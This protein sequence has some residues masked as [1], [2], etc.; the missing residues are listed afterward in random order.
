MNKSINILIS[1]AGRRVSLVEA[2]K[3]ELKLIFPEGK[4]FATDMN[5]SLSAACQV[6]DLAFKVGRI[7][8]KNTILEILDIC[9]KQNIKLV[10]PT[11]DT[12][13]QI[14]AEHQALFN[15][16]GIKII[17]SDLGFIKICRNKWLTNDFFVEKNIPI[18]AKIDKENLSYPFFIKPF[19][20]S[21]SKDIALIQEEK[22]LTR[23]QM[24]NPKLMFMEYL[25]PTQHDEYT[26]DMYYGKDNMLK[27]LV[28]RHRV[29]IRGGEISKGLT[30]KNEVLGYLKEKL[31]KID[32]AIGCLT[33]QLFLHKTNKN[34][35]GIEI[36]PR[37]GGGF[38]MSYQAGANYPK[39]L[40]EEYIVGKRIDYFENWEENLLLLR[41]DTEVIVHEYAL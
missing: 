27:C 23:Q 3:K 39:W 30:M 15:E 26:V 12:E 28:P 6:A 11:I 35:Y 31:Q 7:S 22:D 40:I 29:E 1:S 5:P 19:D 10:V 32:G 20:G 24:E 37:F 13:L 41:Y 21:L 16:N 18:P 9:K 4:V 33:L 14:F 2:F 36:N 17:V 8:E 25:S 34:I 38:P